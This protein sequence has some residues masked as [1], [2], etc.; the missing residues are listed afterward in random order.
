MTTMQ[1]EATSSGTGQISK[2]D[3]Q[4]LKRWIESDEVFILDVR[5]PFEHQAINIHQ[6]QNVP[7]STVS[8]QSIPDVQDRKLILHCKMGSRSQQA[9]R[10]LAEAGIDCYCLEGGIDAWKAAGLPTGGTGKAILDVQ[11]QVFIIVG[12]MILAGSVLAMVTG[13]VWW[14]LLAALPGAGLINAGVSGFCPLAKVVGMM[15]WNKV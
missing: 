6:S 3:P 1:S 14:V 7:L 11:R 5:E 13:N 15:P 2:V 4:T 9:A 8:A 10:K 12:I